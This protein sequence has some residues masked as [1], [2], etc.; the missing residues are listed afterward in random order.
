[1]VVLVRGIGWKG[2]VK[3]Y[4]AISEIDDAGNGPAVL[5]VPGKM[6]FL[7]EEYLSAL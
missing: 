1:M 3:K 2:G 6:H 7:E 5:I 4:C